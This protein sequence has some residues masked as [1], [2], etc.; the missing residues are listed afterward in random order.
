MSVNQI[1]PNPINQEFCQRVFISI[2]IIYVVAKTP[3][4]KNVFETLPSVA[5]CLVEL[6]YEM[7]C[8]S[9]VDATQLSSFFAIVGV[10]CLAREGEA[11]V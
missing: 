8:R 6:W 9:F 11:Y 10:E 7:A 5:V 4:S 3:N 2:I 1:L